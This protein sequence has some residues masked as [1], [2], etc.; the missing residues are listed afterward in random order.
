MSQTMAP[1]L[2]QPLQN[3][4][5]KRSTPPPPPPPLLAAAAESA[6]GRMERMVGAEDDAVDENLAGNAEPSAPR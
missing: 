5:G 4:E 6:D 3:S 2:E 1:T